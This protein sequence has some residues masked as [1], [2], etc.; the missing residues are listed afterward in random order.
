MLIQLTNVWKMRDM[1][2]KLKIIWSEIDVCFTVSIYFK[3][4]MMLC[5]CLQKHVI[6]S[7]KVA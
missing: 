2:S 3:L 7:S 4:K 5:V 1:S 6:L